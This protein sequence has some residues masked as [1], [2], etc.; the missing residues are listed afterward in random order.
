MSKKEKAILITGASG[1][2]GSSICKTF[3]DDGYFV[4]ATDIE[5]NDVFSD[6]F[7]S[8]DLLNLSNSKDSRSEIRQNLE[9]ILNNKELAGIINNAAIQLTDD[10]E[11]IDLDDFQKT[12]DIN[13][14]APLI[15]IQDCLSF[16]KQSKGTIVNIGSI[17][18]KLTKNG[19]LSYA[20]S[21][22]AI[23][24]LTKSLSVELGKDGITTNLIQPAAT[25]TRMLEAGFENNLESMA[26]LK[27]SHPL[28]RIASP[29]EIAKIA[30]FL[31]QNNDLFINGATISVDGGIGNLLHDPM[32][33]S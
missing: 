28:K 9:D 22:S 26:K 10:I 8:L 33:E 3:Y 13:L 27:N 4:I 1:G 19:F 24:G 30:L 20:V 14:K 15:L 7:L 5:D 12:L 16:L 32:S 21:K 6:K 25:Q 23:E 2:I 11:N 17:H 18:S 29:S 31:I